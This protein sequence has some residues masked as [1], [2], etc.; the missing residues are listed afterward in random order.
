MNVTFGFFL[1]GKNNFCTFLIPSAELRQQLNRL[2]FDGWK[3]RGSSTEDDPS[4]D[5]GM[6]ELECEAQIYIRDVLIAA[7]LY[8]G[9]P[10]VTKPIQNWVFKEV[11]KIYI[12]DK[13]SQE[14]TISAPRENHK[15]LFDLLNETLLTGIVSPT[16][17]SRIISQRIWPNPVVLHG[18][19]L[20]DNIWQS[21]QQYIYPPPYLGNS[22]DKMVAYDLR[23]GNWVDMAFHKA[24]GI[25]KEVEWMILTDLV[26]EVTSNVCR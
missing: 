10:M 11:E 1:S 18:Q 24:E 21:L 5:S 23:R 3:E 2:Q 26:G 13:E 16:N 12:Q 15:V 9:C 4:V 8:E 14:E 22:L 20:V 6:T 25:G 7:G 17:G 19:N